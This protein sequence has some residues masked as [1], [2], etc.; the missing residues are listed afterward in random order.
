MTHVNKPLYLACHRIDD[1]SKYTGAERTVLAEPNNLFRRSWLGGSME[2]HNANVPSRRYE[3]PATRHLCSRD[4][5]GV[6]IAGAH[7]ACAEEY[8]R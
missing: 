3:V 2:R 5:D 1:D 8:E 4:C 7:G 6:N